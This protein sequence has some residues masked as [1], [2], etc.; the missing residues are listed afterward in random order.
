MGKSTFSVTRQAYWSLTG[1]ELG[2]LLEL[3]DRTK[4][5]NNA[6]SNHLEEKLRRVSI[7]GSR[8]AAFFLQ[9]RP[10]V[11]KEE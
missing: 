3:V 7:S 11:T 6:D 8:E 2:V 10:R 5:L 4:D 9:L 1:E